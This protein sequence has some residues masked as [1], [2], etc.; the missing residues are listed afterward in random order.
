MSLHASWVFSLGRRRAPARFQDTHIKSPLLQINPLD[1]SVSFR[2]NLACFGSS[3]AVPFSHPPTRSTKYWHNTSTLRSTKRSL[4][5]SISAECCATEYWFISYYLWD[6][7]WDTNK[8]R[9]I[10]KGRAQMTAKTEESHKNHTAVEGNKR[11]EQLTLAERVVTVLTRAVAKIDK[12]RDKFI[13]V[14]LM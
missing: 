2:A 1:T 3:T 12:A 9:S 14:G 10:E 5:I 11:N 4:W 8:D 7:K 6:G 13:W